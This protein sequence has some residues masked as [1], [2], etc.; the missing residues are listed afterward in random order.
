MA[1]KARLQVPLQVHLDRPEV[2][3]LGPAV[4]VVRNEFDEEG[5]VEGFIRLILSNEESALV[6]LRSG[7]GQVLASVDLLL[8]VYCVFII[9]C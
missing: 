2:S 6:R 3:I 5:L 8:S 1:S 4:L 7:R 9:F